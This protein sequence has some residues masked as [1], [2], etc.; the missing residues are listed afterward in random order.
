MALLRADDPRDYI[1]SSHQR[2]ANGIISILQTREEMRHGP[3]SLCARPIRENLQL[4]GR[5]TKAARVVRIECDALT[6][7]LSGDS[8]RISQDSNKRLIR[9][10]GDLQV[11]KRSAVITKGAVR[12]LFLPYRPSG[13]FQYFANDFNGFFSIC[14]RCSSPVKLHRSCKRLL[15]TGWTRAA[16]CAVIGHYLQ[17]ANRCAITRRCGKT[18]GDVGRLSPACWR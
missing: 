12:P 18:R 3:T 11:D 17:A 16:N 13:V 9:P 1:R 5:Y 6:C 7:R 4:S 10:R 2:F 14:L 8:E 15:R